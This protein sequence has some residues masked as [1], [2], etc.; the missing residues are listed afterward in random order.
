MTAPGVDAVDLFLA[1]PMETWG[2]QYS[3]IMRMPFR[4]LM[5]L[6]RIA[7]T[8]SVNSRIEREFAKQLGG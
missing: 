2:L 3:E 4:T 6:N 1:S 8:R 7:T 5:A